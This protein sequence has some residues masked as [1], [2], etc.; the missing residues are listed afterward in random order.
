MKID[1]FLDSYDELKE[2]SLNCEFSDVVCPNDRVVYPN[3]FTEIPGKIREEILSKIKEATGIE[4]KDETMFMRMSPK[5]V[6]CPHKVHHDSLM[7]EYSLMLYLNDGEGGTSIVRHNETGI[8]Y[9]PENE[10]FTHIIQKD[11]NNPEK[12]E[13]VE[14]VQM[15]QNRAFIFEA[16][17]MHCAEPIGG[18]GKDQSDSRIVLTCFFS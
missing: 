18:F 1:N 17:R 4:P 13:R 15:K 9:A 2:L 5:G 11:Q 8:G 7:G 6:H 10:I 3:I 14:T 16:N 12:W